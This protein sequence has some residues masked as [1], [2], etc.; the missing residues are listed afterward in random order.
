MVD[1]HQPI[2]SCVRPV[3]VVR[4]VPSKIESNMSDSNKN[5]DVSSLKKLRGILLLML[6]VACLFLLG[7]I[8]GKG[9]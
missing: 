5:V 9:I 6:G 7:L 4:M 1:L 3:D 2:R 8:V